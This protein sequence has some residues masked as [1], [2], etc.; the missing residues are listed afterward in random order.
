MYTNMCARSSLGFCSP[1]FQTTVF[2][3]DAKASNLERERGQGR[4]SCSLQRGAKFKY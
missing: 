4:L 2:V 3:G 1:A